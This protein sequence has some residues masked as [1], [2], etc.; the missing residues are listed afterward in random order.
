MTQRRR[1]TA[2]ILVL[3]R[4]EDMDA[5]SRRLGLTAATVAAWHEQC[6]AAE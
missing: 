3:L 5:L 4:I 6:L 1:R 2:A